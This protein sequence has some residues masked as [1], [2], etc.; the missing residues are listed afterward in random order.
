MRSG[1]SFL[2]RGVTVTQ[3]LSFAVWFKSLPIFLPLANGW[4][5]KF[6]F[7]PLRGVLNTRKC[8][9]NSTGYI[10]ANTEQVC[11]HL[12]PVSHQLSFF[13]HLPFQYRL[14]RADGAVVL[15]QR[16]KLSALVTQ[17]TYEPGIKSYARIYTFC[18]LACLLEASIPVSF[19]RKFIVKACTESEGFE[20]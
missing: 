20:Y 12:K 3:M 13:S 9:P 11:G 18:L 2:V 19:Q 6:H 16:L 1:P 7:P 5:F 14:S 4:G 15:Q 17:A 10:H 8:R